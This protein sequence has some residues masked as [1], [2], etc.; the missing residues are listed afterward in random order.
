[1]RKL[2]AG[3]TQ[4]ELALGSR[5]SRRT[6]P[7]ECPTRP[8]HR[9]VGQD[10]QAQGDHAAKHKLDYGNSAA[11][12]MRRLDKAAQA[13]DDKAADLLRQVTDPANPMTVN[14]ACIAMGWRKPPSPSQSSSKPGARPISPSAQLSPLGSINSV[15]AEHR[16][17][18]QPGLN[19]SVTLLNLISPDGQV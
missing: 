4:A 11:A 5:H 7:I 8:K 13:G 10:I 16:S 3:N 17:G 1:M 12:G 9:P 18:P 2:I 19:P 14:R 6:R 15:P